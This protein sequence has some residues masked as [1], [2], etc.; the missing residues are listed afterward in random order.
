[1]LNNNFSTVT[2]KIAM[3]LKR[4]GIIVKCENCCCILNDGIGAFDVAVPI[5]D[6]QTDT[7][8]EAVLHCAMSHDQHVVVLKDWKNSED[9]SS[10]P[11]RNI[12]TRLSEALEFVSENRICGNQKLCPAEVVRIAEKYG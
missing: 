6:E 9:H 1:M 3:G 12:Q 11:P 7:A 5:R 2:V 8:G 10:S 4:N